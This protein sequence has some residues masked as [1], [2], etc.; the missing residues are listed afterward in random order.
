MIGGSG[1]QTG[2]GFRHVIA[3][4]AVRGG[5]GVGLGT[6]DPVWLGFHIALKGFFLFCPLRTGD[7]KARPMARTQKM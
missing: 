7:A 6:I 5:S 4:G 1:L 2:G 3:G